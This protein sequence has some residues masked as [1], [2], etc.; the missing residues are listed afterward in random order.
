[1]ESLNGMIYDY[2]LTIEYFNHAGDHIFQWIPAYVS[3]EHCEYWRE[4]FVGMLENLNGATV[5]EASCS[6]VEHLKKAI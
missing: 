1:M 3:M 5:K 2:A 4:Y 6:V